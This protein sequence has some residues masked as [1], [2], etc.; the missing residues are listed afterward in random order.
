MDCEKMAGPM[1]VT[2][3]MTSL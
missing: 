3:G 2:P 1:F